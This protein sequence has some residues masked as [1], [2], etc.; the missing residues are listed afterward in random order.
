MGQAQRRESLSATRWLS[1]GHSIPLLLIGFALASGCKVRSLG[2][3]ALS[4]I[5]CQADGN[6]KDIHSSVDFACGSKILSQISQFCALSTG[7]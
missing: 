1:F 3:F 5:R 4:S 6:Y 2:A 7:Q